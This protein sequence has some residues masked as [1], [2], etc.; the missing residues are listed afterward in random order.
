MGV[1]IKGG[2]E[3]A[4]RVACCKKGKASLEKGT[5]TLPG[6]AL[7]DDRKKRR[8]KG[9]RG[10]LPRATPGACVLKGPLV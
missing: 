8:G 7:H 2:P 9:P 4:E 3:T 5:L 1:V 10:E 6:T